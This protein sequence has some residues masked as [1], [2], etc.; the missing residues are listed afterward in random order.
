MILHDTCALAPQRSFPIPPLPAPP[1]AD[2]GSPLL[3]Q[4][5][6]PPRRSIVPGTAEPTSGLKCLGFSPSPGAWK[7]DGAF[8]WVALAGQL[9][10]PRASPVPSL[11]RPSGRSD[12]CGLPWAVFIACSAKNKSLE[13]WVPR[14][15]P[16]V[17]RMPRSPRE[18]GW[19]GG[20]ERCPWGCSRRGP[21]GQGCFL[22]MVELLHRCL[23]WRCSC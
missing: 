6:L 20:V 11:P 2:G 12:F 23:T 1:S 3:L 5:P 16:R 9:W 10:P 21:S 22:E 17:R 7:R 13:C 4:L 15:Q 18:G 19:G 14:S 8:P